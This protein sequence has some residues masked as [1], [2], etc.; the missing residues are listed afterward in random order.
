MTVS[1]LTEVQRDRSARD[2]VCNLCE[3]G[4][5]ACEMGGVACEM[6]G[7]A[8]EMGGVACEMG[9]AVL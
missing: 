5:M 8:C 1:K 2:K 6:G 7:V 3:I 9:G 4:G